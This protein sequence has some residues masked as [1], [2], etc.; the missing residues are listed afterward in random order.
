[1][2][3]SGKY[4]LSFTKPSAGINETRTVYPQQSA[5]IFVLHPTANV[6]PNMADVI[7]ITLSQN[8]PNASYVN[9]NATYIDAS[10][11]TANVVFYIDADNGT[12]LYTQTF[13]TGT[14]YVNA[15]KAVPNI[16]STAYVWGCNASSATYGTVVKE[17]G[18]IMKGQAG[19]LLNL[20]PC[21]GYAVGWGDEC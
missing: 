13:T 11:G 15:S 19:K 9:L 3:A 20:D 6:V 8:A 14:A 1:M 12:R 5:Y 7:N 2:I 16:K 17:Q 4:L 18:I 21:G 10:G